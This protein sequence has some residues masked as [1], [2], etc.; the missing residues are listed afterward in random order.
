MSEPRAMIAGYEAPIYRGI[1]ERIL[2]MGAP[3]LLSVA[4][5]PLPGGA[6]AVRYRVLSVDGH[7]VEGA[8]SFTV[9]GGANGR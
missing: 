4:L 9:A 7:V 5:P 2:T 6:Y 1:W 8:Y 3:R